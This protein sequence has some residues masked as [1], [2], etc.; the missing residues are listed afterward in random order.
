MSIRLSGGRSLQTP[1]GLTTRPT[2]ARVRNAVFNIWQLHVPNC[3][4]L[5]LCTGSGAM[6]GEALLRGAS[7]VWGIEQSPKACRAI[8]HNWQKLQADDQEVRLL[9]GEVCRILATLMAA[10]FDLIYF[11]P[12]YDSDLYEPVLALLAERS[13]LKTQGEIAVEHRPDRAIA[14]PPGFTLKQSRR[15]GSTAI[16][17]IT[18]KTKA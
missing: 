5:D 17:L 4:W 2:P 9:K 11:D 12:P 3:R 14:L 1:A 16:S 13:L 8:A 15:Y 18:W 7:A 10:P 6:G